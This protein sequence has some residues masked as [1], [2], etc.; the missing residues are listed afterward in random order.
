LTART[1]Y[2]G[3]YTLG[4][5]TENPKIKAINFKNNSWM[6]KYRYL[7]VKISD[8]ITGIKNYRAT[9]NDRWILMEYDTKTETLTHDFNDGVVTDTKNNL[10][11]IVTDNVGNSSTFESIFYRK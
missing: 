7:K 1:K 10:K 5:D 4:I 3:D 2:L 8:G 11:I 6:S 9:L